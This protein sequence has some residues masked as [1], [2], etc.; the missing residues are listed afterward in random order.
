MKSNCLLVTVVLV[1]ISLVAGFETSSLAQ[2]QTAQSTQDKPLYRWQFNAS[3]ATGTVF[4]PLSGKLGASVEGP[5]Q[6]S[7]SAPGALMLDG[8]S[9]S[10]HYIKVTDDIRKVSLPKKAMTLEAWVKIE[11]PQEWGGI[12]SLFQDNGAFERG[13]MLGFQNSQFTFGLSSSNAKKL[14]YLK[15]RKTFEPGYW[16]QVAGTYD[17]TTQR[18]YVDGELAGESS[19]Q[20]GDILYPPKAFFSIGAYHDDNEFYATQGEI[21]QVSLWDRTLTSEEIRKRF[22]TGKSRFPEI[23]SVRPEVADWPT[24]RRDNQ[25]TGIAEENL[26]FPLTAQWIHTARH[27]PQPAWPAPA[28]EDYWH[29]KKGLRARV[30]YDRAYHVV[31]AD[32]R[33]F[34]SSSADDQVHCL[35]ASTGREIWSFFTE[36]PVRL[37]PTIAGNRVLFGSDDG[38]VY[39]LKTSNGSLEWKYRQGPSERR[40][41]GN[42]RVIS[43][44]P[45]RT[46]ILVEEEIAYFC[47]GQFPA[48]GVYQAAVDIQTGKK[49]A[50]GKI[51]IAAQG[52]LERR[53]GQLFVP[54]G[55]D[56]AGAFVSQLKRRGK[57]VGRELSKI[58]TEYPYEF[59][60]AGDVRFGGGDG[61]VAAFRVNDGK[62]IWSATV[63][64][65]AYS[66]AVAGGN[67]YVSTDRG[68]V[69]CFSSSDNGSSRSE[70][71][72]QI[73][74][75]VP[76][77][78]PYANTESKERTSQ[79]AEWILSQANLSQ[80]YCLVL[81]SGQGGLVY[82][83]AKQSSLTIIG[84]E[85]DL[86]K[87]NVSRTR[88]DAAGLAGQV[89]IHH[90]TSG[91]KLP[92]TDYMFN[93]VVDGSLEENISPELKNEAMRVLRP[94]G[95]VAVFSLKQEEL[96]RRGP[97]KGIGEWSHMYA[98]AAN[99][100]CSDDER[101]GGAM[102]LQWYGRPGPENMIDRHHRTV[103]PL[104][105]SG[106]LFV[107]GNNRIFAADAYNGT[108]LWS[109]EVPNSRRIGAY[110]DCSYLVA[111]DDY[112]YV[113]ADDHC[114]GVNVKTGSAEI[115]FQV[116]EA[117]D[118]KPRDWGYVANVD[119][120][121][122]GSATKP[123]AARR[124]HSLKAINEGSFWDY[125][126]L[127]TSDYLF[128]LD[129]HKGTAH[130]RYDS[131]WGAIINS[132]ITVGDGRAYFV[133]S[134]NPKTLVEPTGRSRPSTLVE[135][136]TAIVALDMNSGKLLWRRPIDLSA[137]QHNVYISYA[138][139]KLAV[140]GSHNSGTK[141]ETSNVL[142]SVHVLEAKNGF[143]VWQTTQ[144]QSTK[145][146]GDHGEQDHHP[147]IVGNKLYCEPFAYDLH[148][149]KPIVG[150]N[151]ENKHR[152]GCGTISASASSFFFR[153]SNPTMFDLASNQYSKV[154]TST[155]PGC[156]INMIP[157]G[158]LLLIPEASSGCTCNYAVQ[159]SL[160]FLP[161]VG[162]EREASEKKEQE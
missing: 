37:A 28:K 17:G 51:E 73:T 56:P 54:T 136:G 82:E 128:A 110:R 7:K 41:P 145:I 96:Q 42:E 6:F 100:V 147:V 66:L 44:W 1:A 49:I 80:G 60:G 16:Y 15:A 76:V 95:G 25:R 117:K 144:K 112:L 94:H 153:K 138:E 108:Q 126:P 27:A 124:G 104:Y 65:K 123:G 132:T 143:H 70:K 43:V 125:R 67:L 151:W 149:G 24:W 33:V 157:A 160:A 18:I 131:E 2:K 64:G 106:R 119:K 87:V 107:P 98:N 140:V 22:L 116:P 84:V 9:K 58:E 36:G 150:W 121:L 79:A 142:Y 129:R 50:S 105:K 23:D 21:D 63:E 113:A 114:L 139:G 135:Q 102:A 47:A 109:I 38:Y 5:V 57:G 155:R 88:L 68:K 71:P 46:G 141:K 10:R 52:Y 130:W 156:W 20:S 93:L 48:Q 101:V 32:D 78:F 11:K 148:T 14:T 90:L 159:T 83:L 99:T 81:N 3:N 55:R 8:D 74:Q 75:P 158:G 152:R 146:G 59:I 77:A 19:V 91:E 13:W 137:I 45:V 161:V 4:K 127:V 133:E 97:L 39:C 122:F 85:A 134:S 92:Y 40:I 26:K 12:I 154:T 62:E 86:R 111:T 118:G 30:T 72:M 115:R 31:S 89:S 29:K 69:Y 34:Y 103:A 35:D 162:G 53:G 61:K 120:I